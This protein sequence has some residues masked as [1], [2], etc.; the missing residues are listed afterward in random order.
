MATVLAAWL[1]HGSSDP[2]SKSLAPVPAP[3]SAFTPSSPVSIPE[4]ADE[5]V[6]HRLQE[7][8]PED[9]IVKDALTITIS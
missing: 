1:S 9:S 4:I 6:T 5:D 2:P 7:R 3:T 8:G